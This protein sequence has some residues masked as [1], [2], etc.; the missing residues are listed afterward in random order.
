M[1]FKPILIH[2]LPC[3]PFSIRFVSSKGAM[4]GPIGPLREK[5]IIDPIKSSF[6]LVNPNPF[7]RLAEQNCY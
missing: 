6:S 5:K 7:V 3:D 2:V 1:S 4:S